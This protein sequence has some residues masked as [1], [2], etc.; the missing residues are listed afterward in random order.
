MHPGSAPQAVS[1]ELVP[2]FGKR[3]DLRHAAVVTVV[4]L[5]IYA[6]GFLALEP[7]LGAS[8][9]A[10]SVL[11]VLVIGGLLGPE[12]GIAG[13]PLTLVETGV[14]WGLTGHPIGQPGTT[15]RRPGF[16]WCGVL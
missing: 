2:S 15:D 11:P 8:A 16:G 5:A 6:V 12:I 14:L 13:A 1:N 7:T 10:F 9:G 3:V 4:T